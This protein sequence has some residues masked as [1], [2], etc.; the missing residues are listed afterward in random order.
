MHNH[1]ILY[2]AML[3]GTALLAQGD[4]YF[5]WRL[6]ETSGTV[7]Y[8]QMGHGN[9]QL[10]G[11]TSWQPG[12]GHFQGAL[13]FYGNDARVDLGPCD[14]T[15]GNGEELSVACWFKP[16]IVSGTE[17]ILMIKTLGP[18]ETDII[19]S[20]SLVNNTGARFR[21]RTAGILHTVDIPASSIFSNTW[22]HLAATYDGTNIRLFLNG[23]FT[24]NGPASGSIGYHPQAPATLGNRF[25]NALPFYGALD[26]VRIY[27]RAVNGLEVIDLVI[28]NVATGLEP[29]PF[30]IAGDGTVMPGNGDWTAVRIT[31]ASG[32][33][34]TQQPVAGAM[35]R[36]R[37]PALQPGIYTVS[38]L[39][40]SRVAHQNYVSP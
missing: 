20:L 35:A 7:A 10:Q 1:I 6:D 29:A 30:H 34:L 40:P 13:R 5:H 28:G 31:D 38:L 4:P 24:A 26:D 17:R 37:L 11:N 22:Y 2:I 8:D 39:S 14:L 18:A 32:R 3:S 15:Q 21:L 33:I 27:D 25:D 12:G 36:Y 16:E 9:G 23:S 19:W